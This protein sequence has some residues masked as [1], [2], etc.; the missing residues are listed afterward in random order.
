MEDRLRDNIDDRLSTQLDAVRLE[1]RAQRERSRDRVRAKLTDR[2]PLACI[3]TDERHCVVNWNP[4]AEK[5]FGYT[6]AEALGA[7]APISCWLQHSRRS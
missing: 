7:I 1:R 6:E 5:I 2:L 3:T 4:A